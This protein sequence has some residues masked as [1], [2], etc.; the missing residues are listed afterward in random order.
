MG[1]HEKIASDVL[2]HGFSVVAVAS[3][4]ISSPQ[5]AYTVGLYSRIGFELFV[6]GLPMMYAHAII[7]SLVDSMNF[8]RDVKTTEHTNLPMVL[9]D[10]D[11]NLGKLYDKFVVQAKNYWN[12]EIQ[13]VQIVL[14]DKNAKFP[15]DED[16]DH[17]Y[18]DARQPL[19]VDCTK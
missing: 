1:I 9:K 4:G 17:A 7:T 3:D 12:R 2:H 15:W 14:C 19:F 5:F 11:Q 8:A 10:A 13:I 6:A 18:M 16:F